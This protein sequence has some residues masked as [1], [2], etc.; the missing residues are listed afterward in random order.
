MGKARLLGETAWGTD[1]EL[2]T[3]VR[4]GEESAFEELFS[5]YRSRIRAYISGILA[6]FDRAE[7]ITQEVFI[8][9]LRRLRDTERPIA[10]KPWIYQIAK[11]ACIDELRRTRRNLEVPFDHDTSDAGEGVDLFS[12]EPG[13]DLAVESKQQLDD[14]RRAFLGMSEVHR[15]VLVLRELEGLSYG[16]IAARLG[17]TRPVVE[18]TLFRARRR[19]AEEYEG[20]ISGRSCERTRELIDSLEMHPAARL[21]V[22]DRRRLTRHLAQ[23]RPCRRHATLARTVDPLPAKI[24]EGS[25]AAA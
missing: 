9:A 21:G 20:L 17:M 6:D 10:F 23:C 25:L 19:L 7:D 2:V 13:A 1:H 22:R 8:S 15:R 4:R 12:C 18:S 24:A 5:R 14:L 3:A 16:E 11:N